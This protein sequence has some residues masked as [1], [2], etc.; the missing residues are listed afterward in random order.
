MGLHPQAIATFGLLLLELMQRDYRVIVSTHSPVLLDLAWAIRELRETGESRAMK[1]LA[2]IFGIPR[3][4]NQ[5]RD[6]CLL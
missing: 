1:A 2:R 6:I 3:L 4:S 5:V